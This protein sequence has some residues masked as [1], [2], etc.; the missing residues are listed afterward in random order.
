MFYVYVLQSRSYP[1]ELY[2]GS[3]NNLRKRFLAHNN[4]IELS[5]KRYMP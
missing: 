5:T 2:V 3:T 1:K 4:G